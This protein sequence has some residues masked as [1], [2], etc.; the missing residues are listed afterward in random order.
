MSLN[1]ETIYT[2]F[3]Q[4]SRNLGLLGRVGEHRS[5]RIVVDCTRVLRDFPDARIVCACRRTD[6]E[7]AYPLDLEIDGTNRIIT[8][9]NTETSFS[10]RLTLELRA[11]VDDVVYK[12]SILIGK[13]LPSITVPDDAPDNPY[14]DS[15]DRLDVSIKNTEEATEEAHTAAEAARNAAA[16]ITLLAFEVNCDDG[17][18]YVVNPERLDD[19]EFSVDS[20]GYLEVV[21]DG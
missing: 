6:S 1:L 5:R 16:S 9:T 4:E 20:E 19:I 13:I 17:Y 7:Y 11:M 3:D 10:T 15:L 2:S 8:L 12:S 14:R 21:V 18:L